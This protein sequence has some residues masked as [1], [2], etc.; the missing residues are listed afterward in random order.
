MRVMIVG[1]SRDPQKFGHRSVRAH[2]KAGHEVLPV[3]PHA[4]Q[5]DG[6][7]A[8]PDI[9]SVPGPVDRVSVY[10]PP[11]AGTGF[12]E[13]VADRGDVKEVWLN[14]GAETDQRVARA[15]ALGLEPIVACSIAALGHG[16]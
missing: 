16:L 7:E 5:I 10:L 3:N 13:E 4:D 8:Y 2:R 11:S 12:L 1:A 6:A 9:A 14:P 15:K